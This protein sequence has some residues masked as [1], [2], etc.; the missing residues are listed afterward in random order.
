MTSRRPYL[1]RAL[2]E[3]I[4]DNSMTPFVVADASV[5]GVSVPGSAIRDGKVTLNISAQ[6]V[7]ALH[8]GDDAVSFS[9]RFG[10]VACKVVLPISA[11]SAIYAS[12]NGQGMMFPTEEPEVEDPAQEKSAASKPDKTGGHL[13]VVK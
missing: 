13:K 3:W 12:E 2:Y 7:Q 4:N 9:A 5:A 1:I 10:G 11:V 6:A 8:L